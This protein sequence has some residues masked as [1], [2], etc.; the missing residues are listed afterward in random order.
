MSSMTRT[1][2]SGVAD[3]NMTERAA[4]GRD[5]LSALRLSEVLSGLSH[6]LDITEGQ[7]RGHAER[8]C[9]IGMRLA[10][11]VGLDQATRS[12]LFYAL[13]LKDAGCSS[14]ASKIVALF[15]ADDAIIKSARRLT[16]TSSRA[17]AMLHVLKTVAP[18]GSPVTKARH[19]GA[20]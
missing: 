11:A 6:A 7:P 12:S 8:S 3:T 13:L 2:G 15:G 16:D 20:V 4:E 9:V 5:G 10:E 18:E 14:I 1:R 17:Q 19:F